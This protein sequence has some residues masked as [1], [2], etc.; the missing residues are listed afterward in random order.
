MAALQQLL[1]SGATGAKSIADSNKIVQDKAKKD[2]KEAAFLL[3]INY[4]DGSGGFT[5]NLDKAEKYLRKA[6]ELNHC[7]ADFVLG[8]LLLEHAKNEEAFHFIS[9]AADSSENVKAQWQLGIL[10]SIGHGCDHNEKLARR[11][12]LRAER[13]GSKSKKDINET[14][15]AGQKLVEFEDEQNLAKVGMSLQDRLERYMQSFVDDPKLREESQSILDFLKNKTKNAPTP[16]TNTSQSMDSISEMVHRAQQGSKVAQK[17]FLAMSIM[18]QAYADLQ[19]NNFQQAFQKFRE[20]ER[21]WDLLPIKEDEL[22]AFYKAAKRALDANHNDAEA[23]FVILRY[24][25]LTNFHATDQIRMAQK[26]VSLDPKV[27]NFHH[28]LGA[29]HGFAGE[30]TSSVRCFDRALELDPIPEWLYDRASSLRLNSERNPSEVIKAYEDYI[31]ANEPDSR[32]V[33]EAYY[34]IGL[35]YMMQKNNEKAEEF[36]KKAIKAEDPSVRLPYFR[37][38]EDDFPPKFLLLKLKMKMRGGVKNLGK[39]TKQTTKEVCQN[40]GKGSGDVL[41]QCSQCK[42]AKYCDRKCQKENWKV[43]KKNCL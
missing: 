20:A 13:Q 16:R 10:Y 21:T 4:L 41:L 35:E 5:K 19:K 42:T 12:L 23:L 32:K 36:L 24:Q 11:W 29:L 8:S 3:G 43:H 34:C 22:T 14:I 7:Q 27:A 15:K 9:R 6:S 33:P 25:M 17:L 18:E 39:E 37:P 1:R 28:I 31:S 26:C 40:C 38:V 30:Y 2:D